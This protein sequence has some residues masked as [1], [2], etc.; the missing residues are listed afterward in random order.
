[1][2]RKL[3]SFQ[4]LKMVFEPTDADLEMERYRKANASIRCTV[5][6]DFMVYRVNGN[7]E[8]EAKKANALIEKLG[9][10]LRAVASKITPSYCIEYSPSK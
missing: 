10:Q 8:I 7:P 3:K 4:E 9:L 2:S 5:Y 1:M 6:E